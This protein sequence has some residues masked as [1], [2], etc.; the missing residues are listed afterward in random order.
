MYQNNLDSFLVL[1]CHDSN[2]FKTFEAMLVNKITEE[3]EKLYKVACEALLN[4][5]QK[6]FALEQLGKVNAYKELNTLL[7]ATFKSLNEE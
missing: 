6:A 3:S 7:K 1:C 2:L 4:D 5:S